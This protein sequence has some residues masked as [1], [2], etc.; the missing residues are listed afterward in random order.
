MF[1]YSN[2]REDGTFKVEKVW[3]A[4]DCGVA[5]NP[6]NVKAQMEGGIG[7]G[8]AAILFSEITLTDG[9]VDQ[10]NFDT[11]QPMRMEHA[12]LVEVEV[13]ASAAAPTGA[14]EPGTP[15][16]GPAVANAI[17]AATGELPSVL[18]LAKAGMV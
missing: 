18:P 8:L 15:P 6:D 17:L 5:V 12:P 7:Y 3:C 14:G 1:A 4:A 10:E 11:Y 2:R 13:I 16:V 9:R